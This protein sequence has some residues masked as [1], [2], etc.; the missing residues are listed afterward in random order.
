MNCDFK[1]VKK[2]G[3]LYWKANEV[4]RYK[5]ETVQTGEMSEVNK[6]Y[7]EI[8]QRC[9]KFCTDDL[10]FSVREE[11]VKTYYETIFRVTHCEDGILSVAMRSRL[12]K[13]DQDV[14]KVFDAKNWEI[15]SGM[16]LPAKQ[17]CSHLG[18]KLGRD[19]RKSKIFLLD[20]KIY[21]ISEIDQTDIFC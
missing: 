10:Y 20:G 4:L 6:F 3:R 12:K 13:G 5:I 8:A 21:D 11:R 16:L 2:S 1:Y 15:S 9:E 14:Y 18:S 19:K 17:L 7:T